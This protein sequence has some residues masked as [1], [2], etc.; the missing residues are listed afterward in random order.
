MESMRQARRRFIVGAVVPAGISAVLAVG[1]MTDA[2]GFASEPLYLVGV[3]VSILANL[4]ASLYSVYHWG[5]I[6]HYLTISEA[7]LARIAEKKHDSDEPNL[8]AKE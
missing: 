5:K 8:E 4:G 6:S 7:I 2:V 3:Q 1:I